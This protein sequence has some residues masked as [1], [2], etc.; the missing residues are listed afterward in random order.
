MRLA[1]ENLPLVR[2]VCRNTWRDVIFQH[3]APFYVE[4]FCN[5]D[6]DNASTYNWAEICR[7]FDEMEP[8]WHD[9]AAC[10][11]AGLENSIGFGTRF[12]AAPKE[13]K[14]ASDVA[15][16]VFSRSGASV[17]SAGVAPRLEP[18]Y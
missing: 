7:L 3:V 17:Y 13:P 12:R 16:R 9:L 4:V 8:G 5:E 1:Q 14:P 15:T 10:M 2:D 6:S 18:C 11:L